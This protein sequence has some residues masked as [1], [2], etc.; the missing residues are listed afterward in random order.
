MA[1]AVS[2]GGI[3]A[4]CV[5]VMYSTEKI[6]V[7]VKSGVGNSSGVGCAAGEL[8]ASAANSTAKTARICLCLFN[9]NAS[10]SRSKR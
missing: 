7:N 4:G 8:H 2:E 3:G 1:V 10:I 5:G 9:I 6:A